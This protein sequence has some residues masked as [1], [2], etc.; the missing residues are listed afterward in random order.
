MLLA[1]LCFNVPLCQGLKQ[2]GNSGNTISP[3]SFLLAKCAQSSY[4]G[5]F[6][7]QSHSI[8]S[9][10]HFTHSLLS[11]DINLTCTLLYTS[12]FT[13]PHSLSHSV[14]VSSSPP[15]QSWLPS[16]SAVSG[17]NSPKLQVNVCLAAK[18]MLVFTPESYGKYSI[19]QYRNIEL[20]YQLPH[21]IL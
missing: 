7:S 21:Q 12:H 11:L 5:T 14:V 16:Q 8:C 6:F 20:L 13:F 17:T 1:S 3:T 10:S 19:Y 18:K 9:I 2:P 4:T 15:V